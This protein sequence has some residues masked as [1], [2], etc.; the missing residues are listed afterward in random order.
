MDPSKVSNGM[1]TNYPLTLIGLHGVPAL[2]AEG[3]AQSAVR[4]LGRL[5]QPELCQRTDHSHISVVSLLPY[6]C[7][8]SKSA[9]LLLPVRR[10]FSFSWLSFQVF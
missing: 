1:G 8:I 6:Q 7:G 5:S 9:G 2:E 10:V 4:G 3:L